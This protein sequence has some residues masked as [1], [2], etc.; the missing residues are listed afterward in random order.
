MNPFKTAYSNLK[1]RWRN[2]N[3]A[4][5]AAEPESYKTFGI[6]SLDFLG[7]LGR[8]RRQPLSEVTYFTCLKM[9]SETLAKMPLKFY[10]S[11]EE[12]I[13]EPDD[14]DTSR[15]IKTRPNPF[16]TPTVFWNTVE[17]NRNHYGNAYVYIRRKFI[18]KKYGG[19]LKVLDLWVMQ[20]SCVLNMYLFPDVG[21][22]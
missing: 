7:L 9:L 18:R 21:S 22:V 20:S 14:T 13:I 16:M 4:A 3:G 17:M 6:N 15:L 2:R 5:D 12:G 11:T 19:E 8:K 10:Q 1:E